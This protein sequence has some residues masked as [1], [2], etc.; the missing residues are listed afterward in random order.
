MN[1]DDVPS[2]TG[3]GSTGGGIEVP[4]GEQPTEIPEDPPILLE[5]EYDPIILHPAETE[6]FTELIHE[7]ICVN[8]KKYRQTAEAC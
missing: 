8:N 3:S 7:N 1:P 4:I 2:F 5:I 6:R